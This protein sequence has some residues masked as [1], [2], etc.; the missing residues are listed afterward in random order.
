MMIK[1]LI[2]ILAEIPDFRKAKGKRHPL[3]AILALACVAMM[4][5]YKGYKA[6]AEWRSNYGDELMKAMGF[7]HLKGPCIA[8]FSNIFRGINV[9]LFEEKIGAWA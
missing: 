3:P 8:T 2:E 7:T 5:G 1:P 4:C 6:F 9:K